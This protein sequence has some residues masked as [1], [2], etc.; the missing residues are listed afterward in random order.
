MIL[1]ITSDQDGDV[2]FQRP[3]E[4][5]ELLDCDIYAERFASDYFDA[6]ISRDGHV[7][8]GCGEFTVELADN[9]GTA[10]CWSTRSY[11]TKLE[12]M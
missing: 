8:L 2:L 4:G 12:A 9:P 11:F 6:D 3:L 7:P 5:D 10:V 1:T